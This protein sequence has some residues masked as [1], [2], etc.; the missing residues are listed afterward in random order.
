MF[1]VEFADLTAEPK[2][3][4]FFASDHKLNILYICWSNN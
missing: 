2:F 1:S 4:L 3:I